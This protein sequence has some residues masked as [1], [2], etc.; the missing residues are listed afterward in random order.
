MSV[1]KDLL[2]F[3]KLERKSY[4]IGI[5]VLIIVAIIIIFP[6]Y[7]VGIVVDHII[8]GTLTETILLNW[9]LLLCLVVFYYIS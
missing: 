7:A 5:L 3:F 4:I 6:P 2:W 1:F 9:I 8:D